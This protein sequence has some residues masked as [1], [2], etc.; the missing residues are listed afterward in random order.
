MQKIYP[1]A[2]IDVRTEPKYFK[3]V[4][5]NVLNK[6]KKIPLLIL[7]AVSFLFCSIVHGQKLTL[8]VKGGAMFSLS[9]GRNLRQPHF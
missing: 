7:I 4:Q 3:F 5:S 6:M 2:H 9:D 8:G 1:K